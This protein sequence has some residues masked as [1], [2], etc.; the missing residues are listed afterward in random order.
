M[1]WL[2]GFGKGSSKNNNNATTT[3]GSALIEERKVLPVN[4]IFLRQQFP[5]EVKFDT[6]EEIINYILGFL[7]ESTGRDNFNVLVQCG[8][9]NKTWNRITCSDK[10]WKLCLTR[11]QVDNSDIVLDGFK[12]SSKDIYF[13]LCMKKITLIFSF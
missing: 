1:S 12:G 11:F 7:L 10:F 4:N 5:V 9:I 8:G 13:E 2:K 6:E 3:V